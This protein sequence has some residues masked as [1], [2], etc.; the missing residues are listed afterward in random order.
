MSGYFGNGYFVKIVQ[1]GAAPVGRLRAR[2]TQMPV[3]FEETVTTGA[4]QA[5]EVPSQ[6]SD[7]SNRTFTDQQTF[8]AQHESPVYPDRT[9]SPPLNNDSFMEPRGLDAAL[10]TNLESHDMMVPAV[11]ANPTVE[12]FT[13][14]SHPTAPS[15]EPLNISDSAIEPF[16]DTAKNSIET[17]SGNRVFELRMPEGF[18]PST[19]DQTSRVDH[20]RPSPQTR[21][22]ATT[23]NSQPVEVHTEEQRHVQSTIIPK[24]TVELPEL[25]VEL[26]LP[27]P[28][29]SQP[30]SELH[31]PRPTTEAHETPQASAMV[32]EIVTHVMPP[33]PLMPAEVFESSAPTPRAE[34]A[35]EYS[36][37]RQPSITAAPIVP[38]ARL[39]INRLDVQVINQAPAP[40]PTPPAQVRPD[41]SQLL[42]KKHVGRV[43]LL[44]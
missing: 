14:T 21:L 37:F 25:A 20:A 30:V 43:D 22:A 6:T 33:S 13:Q 28:T 1:R 38:P 12:T 18:Y 42:E 15:N 26:S 4:D 34:Q 35:A 24:Q 29:S 11:T 27:G 40:P 32:H 8:A 3:V 16:V 31:Q 39:Q 9:Y 17:R 7:V 19:K 41:V 23:S 5:T 36:P 2:P 10:T 44:L